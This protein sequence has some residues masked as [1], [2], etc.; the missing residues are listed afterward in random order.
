MNQENYLII[1]RERLVQTTELILGAIQEY[2]SANSLRK[3]MPREQLRSQLKLSGR[4]FN[5]LINRLS[6]EKRVVDAGA[7]VS[8]Q[9]HEVRLSPLQQANRAALLAK[10]ARAPFS[11][12]SIRESQAEIGDDLYSALV[13]MGELIPV[14]S[15]VVF[16]QPDYQVMM[17]EVKRRLER[18]GTLTVAQFRDQFN[19]SRRFAL[20]FLE[21]LDILGITVREGDLRRL[22]R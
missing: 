7:S 4:D 1:S 10:F 17:D 3:G 14:S 2:L 6:T 21:H 11:P 8:L 12:P 15:E 9:G 19:T 16:H 20:A 18:D 22:R 13:E 5:A